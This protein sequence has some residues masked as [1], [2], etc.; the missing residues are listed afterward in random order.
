MREPIVT[1]RATHQQSGA[2]A[3]WMH[4]QGVRVIAARPEAEDDVHIHPGRPGS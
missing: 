2:L 1:T 3:G 4:S